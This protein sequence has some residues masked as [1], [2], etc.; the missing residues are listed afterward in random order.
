MSTSDHQVVVTAEDQQRLLQLLQREFKDITGCK[1]HLDDLLKEVN[2]AS[3]VAPEDISSDVVT[4]D[5]VVKLTDVDSDETE[6]FTL[7]FPDSENVKENMLSVFSPI[8]TAILGY[9]V[10][11]TVSWAVPIGER[12]MKIESI[13]YQPERYRH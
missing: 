10:G 7:V 4:M 6:I 8:G 2:R 12:R 1:S 13:H 5:S 9:R 3:V 11:D